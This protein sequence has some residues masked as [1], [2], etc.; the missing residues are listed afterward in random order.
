[1][2]T[3]KGVERIIRAAFAFAQKSGRKHVHM[4]DKSN[5][6]RHA[7]EL[8]LR[9]FDEVRRE[10]PGI[11]ATHVYIDALCLYIVQDPS[12][13]QVIV[14]NNLFGDIVTDL[15]RRAS[16]RA[17]AWRPAR[18]FIRPIRRASACSSR[19]TARHRPWPARTWRI[20]SRLC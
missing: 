13:F 16:G 1:M 10:Y 9:V 2:N 11:E 17:R 19:S 12:Q 6:M 14:T 7:H 3:R 18:T 4:A 8:W 5:A 15:G 20:P